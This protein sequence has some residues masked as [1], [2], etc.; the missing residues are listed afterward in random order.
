MPFGESLFEFRVTFEAGVDP[1]RGTLGGVAIGAI[2]GI[3]LMQNISDQPRAIT[4]MG[5]VAGSTVL[6]LQREVWMF[7]LNQLGR[8]TT[9][10][11]LLDLL[12]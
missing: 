8:V 11:E 7:L 10:A 12:Y 6:Y 9:L 4:A 1:H 2:I 5:T 3:G